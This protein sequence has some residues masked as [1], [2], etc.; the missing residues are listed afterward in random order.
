MKMV[1]QIING[2]CFY[3]FTNED[4]FSITFSDIGASIYDIRYKDIPLI[5]S[6]K[7]PSR[8]LESYGFHGKSIGR[9]AGRIK[10]AH[11]NYLGKEYV[12][13]RNN[14]AHTLHGGYHSFAFQ[15][16]HLELVKREDTFVLTFSY[17][18]K[19][20]EAGF[21]GEIMTLIRYTIPK[22]GT[23]FLYEVIAE[24]EEATPFGPTLHLYFNL[25]G[26]KNI[27]QHSLTLD[28]EKV[29]RYDES[30]IPLSFVPAAP[31]FSFENGTRLDESLL[32]HPL[33]SKLKGIDHCFLIKGEKEVP[34]LLEN[35]TKKLE[36]S[37]NF[38]ALQVYTDNAPAP[39]ELTN[40][41]IEIPHS[42]VALE[43]MYVATEFLEMGL[44][45]KVRRRNWIRYHFVL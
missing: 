16:F 2:N 40:G 45:P 1:S 41:N 20:G 35:G 23:E 37:T 9:I 27:Y 17:L 30:L 14:G 26:D 32:S 19:D 3:S 42:G 12:L 7:Q 28:S 15:R 11:L 44:T 29:M 4:G 43:P 6:P 10:N 25:G 8:F 5:V 18:S 22:T 38:P 24:A 31:P 34:I 13:E 33:L 36:I 21:P 39:L